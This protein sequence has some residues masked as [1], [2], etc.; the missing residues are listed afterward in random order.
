MHD[1]RFQFESPVG[2]IVVHLQC[3]TIIDL[4]IEVL[5]A[6]GIPAAQ[7]VTQQRI[8][9]QVTDY[10]GDPA[11][12][13]QWQLQPLGS[14]YQRRI[15]R[16]LQA[17]PVG[18]VKTYG[19]LASEIGGSA[20]AV[21]NACRRNPIPVYIPCHRVVAQGGI[22]GFAGETAG[23]QIDIKRWLLQHEGVVI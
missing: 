19:Q 4:D 17:I 12:P 22:G 11:K 7:T 10:F 16:A 20:R 2:M 21:G 15:W 9:R 6:K 18:V 8:A 14:D 1:S 13:L 3:D 5:P 23:R